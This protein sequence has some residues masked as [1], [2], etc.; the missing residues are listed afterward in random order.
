M[1]EAAALGFVERVRVLLCATDKPQLDR[2]DGKGST[3]L[4]KVM[5]GLGGL[6]GLDG[7]QIHE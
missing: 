5:H 6:G 7:C 4:F 1:M 2:R 3:A